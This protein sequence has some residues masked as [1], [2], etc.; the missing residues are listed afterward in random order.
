MNRRKKFQHADNDIISIA[1]EIFV[2]QF[3]QHI[4]MF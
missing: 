2:G 1:F 3:D 4:L